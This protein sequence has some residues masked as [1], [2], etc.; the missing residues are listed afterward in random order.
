MAIY[1]LELVTGSEIVDG[2]EK[3]IKETRKLDFI[4]LAVTRKALIVKNEIE[5]LSQA[6]E[7][8][9]LEIFDKQVEFVADV[10]DVT[11]D[12]IYN[13]LNAYTGSL[14]IKQIFEKIL[15]IEELEKEE[16]KKMAKMAKMLK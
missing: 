9:E 4:S 16:E 12:A 3:F 7:V 8:D 6:K 1:E 14:V 2:K 13:G 15:G 10:F 5:K 11:V